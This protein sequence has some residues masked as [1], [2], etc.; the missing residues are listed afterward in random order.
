MIYE[1]YGSKRCVN[2]VYYRRVDFLLMLKT[3]FR[4]HPTE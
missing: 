3:D 4:F 1:R 2:I